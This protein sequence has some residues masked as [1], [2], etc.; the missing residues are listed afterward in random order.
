MDLFS[1]FCILSIKVCVFCDRA[2]FRL[3][4]HKILSFLFRSIRYDCHFTFFYILNARD[5][6][7]FLSIVVIEVYFIIIGFLSFNL[8]IRGTFI[9]MVYS[10]RT[11]VYSGSLKC[12]LYI[13]V[14]PNLIAVCVIKHNISCKDIYC[15]QIFL[16]KLF[17]SFLLH[18]IQLIF[19]CNRLCLNITSFRNY[20]RHCAQCNR[21]IFSTGYICC[22]LN[23][24]FKYL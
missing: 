2:Q 19:I 3:P 8:S 11:T 17:I 15:S 1:I 5:K 6:Y 4:S 13:S 16:H 21:N 12:N 14:R 9:Y 20:S 22:K 24:T 23:L 18:Q 7:I 10:R